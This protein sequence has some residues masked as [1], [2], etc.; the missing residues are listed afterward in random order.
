MSDVASKR[1]KNYLNS[2]EAG[3]LE[4]Y[5]VAEK[6]RELGYDPEDKVDIPLASDVADRCEGIVG[7]VAPEIIDKGVAER[8]RELEDEFG[9]SDW[10]VALTIAGEVAE[11]KF[12]KYDSVEDALETGVRI[13]L[14]YVTLGVTCAPLEGF[15]ELKIKN[16]MDGGDYCAVYYAGPIRSAGGTASAVSVLIADYARRRVGVGD[17]DPQ[18]VELKRYD[19]EIKDYDERVS[20][21]Q[22][23]PTKEE[24]EFLVKN[25]PVEVNGDP[26][27]RIEVSNYKRLE[28]VETDLIR[29]GMCLVIGEGLSLK[30]KKI[31]KKLNSWG[32][33]FGLSDWMFLKKYIDIQKMLHAGKGN[34]G[35]EGGKVKPNLKFIEELVAGRP[36]FSHPMRYEGFRLR[37]GRSR[38]SGLAAASMHPATMRMT[39]DFIA[40]GVQLKVERPGKAC[41]ISP[42]DSIQPPFVKLKNGSVLWLDS[43]EKVLKYRSQVKEVIF[44]G[45]ILFCYGDFMENGSMLVPPGYVQEWWVQELKD[46][47]DDVDKV[48]EVV[49][50]DLRELFDSPVNTFVSYEDAV[51]L[52]E[53]TGV[54]FNPNYVFFWK[55][56][57]VKDLKL[58]I[59]ALEN[60][61]LTKRELI[62]PFDVKSVLEDLWI[63]HKVEGEDLVL[64][65][66]VKKSLLTNLGF[67]HGFKSV[68]GDDVINLVNELSDF[69]IK[70]V[71]GT[72]VGCRMGRPEKAKM[73][74][75]TGSPQGLFPVGREGG[76]LRSFNTASEEGVVTA[77]FPLFYCSEC[78]NDTIYRR[79]EECGSRTMQRYYCSKC[80]KVSDKTECCGRSTKPYK[81]RGID[82]NHYIRS[83]LTRTGL[84]M[85]NL[86]KG[87]RGVMDKDRL[88]ENFMKAL[89][90]AKNDVYV[91]KD[92]TVR[93]DIIETVCTHFTPEEVELSVEEAKRLG[94]THDVGGKPLTKPSQLLEIL[95][96]DVIL[97][98]CKEWEDASCSEFLIKVCNFVDDELEYLYDMDAY[99]NVQS[100]SDLI[101]KYVISLAP[102]TSA[103]IVSRIIGFSKTQGLYAHPYLHAACRRNADGDEL[104]II[105]LL[106]GLLNFSRQFLPDRRG[107]RTMDAPLV[108]SVKLDPVEVDS[109]AFN[110]D[111]VDHYPL[112]FYKGACECKMPWDVKVKRV[113]DVLD[114]PAQYEGINFTHSCS[115]INSGPVVSAYKTLGSMSDK[116]DEQLKL[117]ET[118]RAV[119]E[120]DVA[121]LIIEKHFLKDLK[122]N[123]RRYSTQ[124]F[125]CVHC[126]NKYRRPPLSGKCNNCGG[127]VI[128]T[129]AEGSVKKYLEPCMLLKD[130]YNVPK[131]LE[132]D[133]MILERKI[134]GL[135]GKPPTKQ[136]SLT[137]V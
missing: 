9:S 136:I 31:I 67:N 103:G 42:C 14:A 83:V 131:Y 69:I 112:S 130:K 60:A 90:R 111:I 15:I 84:Q 79:C 44:A 5:D 132:Q 86:V 123:L 106:D 68:S 124:G 117:A 120:D 116:M 92:G 23:S 30:A 27:S 46:L 137:E 94:Y 115:S 52:S 8:I 1:I 43:E 26:T 104:G 125:R 24:I 77:D 2:V 93:Y 63:E 121:R 128:L 47:I 39:Y 64:G 133:L 109:E 36:V 73:R 29:G 49:S 65:E 87:V 12:Y 95:P 81:K 96:Q 33:D 127:R 41:A 10:R 34:N 32:D 40:T 78:D 129:I 18:P 100:K 6:A 74:K 35:D 56:I 75:M 37:Y 76:R 102:H 82:V 51:K 114:T 118:F 89:L 108:L 45:D 135:F 59:T 126:N 19:R 105:L 4:E 7:A 17:Y 62:L 85:P 20:R 101:G 97:P 107:G 134:E 66:V 57:G 71:G 110:V 38:L 80:K 11:N 58:L 119:D 13:G 48:D 55:N 122:G 72:F 16:R 88:T 99:F 98:D 50:V 54:P 22:Y 70:D 28:R 113:E 53:V 21:L 25:I 3:V 91:N 61:D